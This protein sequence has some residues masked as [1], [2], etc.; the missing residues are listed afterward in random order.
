MMQR[1]SWKKR[2]T[3]YDAL[4]IIYNMKKV[5]K[6]RLERDAGEMEITVGKWSIMIHV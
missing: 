2:Y 6:Y 3:V 1:I 4:C 5:F